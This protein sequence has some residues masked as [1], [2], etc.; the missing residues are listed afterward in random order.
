M[1]PPASLVVALVQALEAEP[2]VHGFQSNA[3]VLHQRWRSKPAPPLTSGFGMLD[4]VFHE[5]RRIDMRTTET[6]VD[7]G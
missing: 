6:D 7:G 3:I 1:F 5:D 2:S 4:Q